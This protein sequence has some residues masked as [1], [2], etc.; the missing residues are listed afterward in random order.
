MRP[1][2]QFSGRNADT[3]Q[4]HF[5]YPDTL[6]KSVVL[7]S[8]LVEINAD[9]YEG[10]DSYLFVIRD[11]IT[12]C[13]Y[14][15]VSRF[16]VSPLVMLDLCSLGGGEVFCVHVK[17]VLG[18]DF[19]QV[20][21]LSDAKLHSSR[22]V[23]CCTVSPKDGLRTFDVSTVRKDED[24]IGDPASKFMCESVR[25]HPQMSVS[26]SR[27]VQVDKPS[28][29][30]WS[31]LALVTAKNGSQLLITSQRKLGSR[32]IRII[33]GYDKS[34]SVGSCIC[35]VEP[36]RSSGWMIHPLVK[37]IES[38]TGLPPV[39]AELVAPYAGLMGYISI[40]DNRRCTRRGHLLGHL[41]DL[42]QK[43]WA[44]VQK[45]AP[46]VIQHIDPF[47]A[48][49]ILIGVADELHAASHG[50][51]S[52]MMTVTGKNAVMIDCVVEWDC[53]SIEFSG[54][55][56]FL[57]VQLLSYVRATGNGDQ[58]LKMLEA[59]MTKAS[60]S[61]VLGNR[62]PGQAM[63]RRFKLSFARVSLTG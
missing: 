35:D 15:T 1:C 29:T 55:S 40:D 33:T 59:R 52:E 31:W 36:G 57:V 42:Y 19:S 12:N 28:N 18:A 13:V 63:D 51:I 49:Q 58:P 39:L 24:D 3:L 16:Q 47:S 22:G 60:T 20:I 53:R 34:A 37:C 46:V 25:F 21:N 11:F 14:A 7:L 9:S 48:V 5:F 2:L 62:Q 32:A 44:R 43:T 61:F 30:S 38:A 27:I 17:A 56:L 23:I 8:R 6:A 50:A 4:L 10:L 41:Y 26:L 54:I 45:T